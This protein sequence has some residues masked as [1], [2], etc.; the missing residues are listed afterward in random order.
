MKRELL[1][2]YG[3]H[4][5]SMFIVNQELGYE[6]EGIISRNAPYVTTFIVGGIT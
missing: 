6:G 1:L 2:F 3:T 5:C 4:I